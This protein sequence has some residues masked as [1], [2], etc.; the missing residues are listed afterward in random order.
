MLLRDGEET[1]GFPEQVA[2][3]E[4][5]GPGSPLVFCEHDVTKETRSV[6]LNRHKAGNRFVRLL[7]R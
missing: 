2:D 7:T 5:I 1:C 4:A 6:D 3:I